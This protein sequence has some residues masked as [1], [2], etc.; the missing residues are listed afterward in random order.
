MNRCVLSVS[1]YSI[2]A[3]VTACWL[4]S[5]AHA[6][7]IPEVLRGLEALQGSVGALQNGVNTLQT[8]VNDVQTAVNGGTL[9]SYQQ[10]ASKN[11]GSPGNCAISFPAVTDKTLILHA[12]CN[13]V[14][15]PNVSGDARTLLAWLHATSNPFHAFPFFSVKLSPSNATFYSFN[16]EAY[17]FVDSGDTPIIEILNDGFAATNFACTISGK[18]L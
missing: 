10:Y 4:V 3:F 11:C 5:T 8:G 6:Q 7:G 12:S 14:I 9:K 16:A 1:R 17:L 15:P 18:V 2:A 13:W